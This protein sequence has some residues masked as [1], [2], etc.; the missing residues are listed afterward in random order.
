MKSGKTKDK[1]RQMSIIEKE[2]ARRCVDRSSF[3]QLRQKNEKREV[4]LWVLV[5]VFVISQKIVEVEVL[6]EEEKLGSW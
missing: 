2:E 4:M 3:R 5:N 6:E 1:Y